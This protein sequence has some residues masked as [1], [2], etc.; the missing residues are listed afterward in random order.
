MEFG[1]GS[2]IG[3]ERTDR[4]TDA[5]VDRCGDGETMA[6][7]EF[8]RLDLGEPMSLH[9]E[10]LPARQR[11]VLRACVGPAQHW[12]PIWPAARR[13]RFISGIGNLRIWGLAGHSRRG[14]TV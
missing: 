11:E 10:A 9:W 8:S 7:R 6:V 2:R 4:G 13:S 12:R 1:A 14:P 5:T 3:A